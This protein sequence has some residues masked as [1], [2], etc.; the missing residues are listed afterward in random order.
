MFNL[1]GIGSEKFY[2][3]I[4]SEFIQEHRLRSGHTTDLSRAIVLFAECAP[5]YS[6]ELC[7]SLD[8]KMFYHNSRM[9]GN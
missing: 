5:L 3:S 6:E 9:T 7:N 4:R 8:E 2:S 1:G